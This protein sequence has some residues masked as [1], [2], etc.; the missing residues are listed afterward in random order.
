[1]A[2]NLPLE[3]RVERIIRYEIVSDLIK[4]IETENPNFTTMLINWDNAPT[5]P[6][7]ASINHQSPK[8]IQALLTGNID[9]KQPGR[10]GDQTIQPLI[11]NIMRMNN[12]R[13][14][15]ND[16][17]FVRQQG[18]L[19][20]K[21]LI[22]SGCEL[23]VAAPTGET[24]LFEL[25]FRPSLYDSYGHRLFTYLLNKGA[26]PNFIGPNTEEHYSGKVSILDILISNT[27]DV[28]IVGIMKDFN[29]IRD[30]RREGTVPGTNIRYRIS[31]WSGQTLYDLYRMLQLRFDLALEK[32]AN[33]QTPG[34]SIVGL[35]AL[36]T[37]RT[38]LLI[39]V[40]NKMKYIKMIHPGLE[41]YNVFQ[42]Y[43][44][45]LLEIDPSLLNIDDPYAPVEFMIDSYDIDSIR[46]LVAAGA[47]VNR[48]SVRTGQT[49]LIKLFSNDSNIK[50][51]G[52]RNQLMNLLT[53]LLSAGAN[54][55]VTHDGK[56]LFRLGFDAIKGKT[57][58]NFFLANELFQADDTQLILNN[59]P[60]LIDQEMTPENQE[61][62]AA[63][64]TP[65]YRNNTGQSPLSQMLR[66]GNLKAIAWLLNHG[67]GAE[68]KNIYGSSIR[69]ILKAQQN[70]G[71]RPSKSFARALLSVS[72][73]PPVA[74]F[75]AANGL[76]NN[77]DPDWL[78]KN[79][80]GVFK[81][82]ERYDSILLPMFTNK[83]RNNTGSTLLHK[84]MRMGNYAAAQ[85][86]TNH[87]LYTTDRNI[88]GYSPANVGKLS[89]QQPYPQPVANL[90][91][92]ERQRPR[93]FRNTLR[94]EYR[95]FSNT[96]RRAKG[97][98]KI[99]RHRSN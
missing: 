92:I 83:P 5:S 89:Q 58:F 49:P 20:G 96:R 46:T 59:F 37:I 63:I 78:I 22:D 8:I 52:H 73:T 71:P 41:L 67:H 61:R 50:Q 76:L 12:T 56:T 69:N 42:Y 87:N 43:L 16:E 86:L 19:I 57:L 38:N 81:M 84:A 2:A 26:D 30:I 10:L 27:N 9:I 88:Y 32:G 72:D 29:Q 64:I 39:V 3:Q 80:Q 90:N 7:I 66:S 35:R 70:M 47:D 85:W 74:E 18:Y 75:L 54:F 6:L 62:L 24:P 68:S 65:D 99:T 60:M 44:N 79:T 13:T 95:N 55:K 15:R 53:I 21:L 45:R 82:N 34:I 91:T 14:S 94:N 11:A 36:E 4:L 97:G 98:R 48:A 1:M 31:D 93:T 77:E 23:N 17:N 25:C 40:L 28:A 51:W 33:T